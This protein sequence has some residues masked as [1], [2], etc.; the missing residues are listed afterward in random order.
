MRKMEKFTDLLY[1]KP[2]SKYNYF[3][4]SDPKRG[5]LKWVYLSYLARIQTWFGINDMNLV[6]TETT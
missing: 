4:T 3:L 1:N 5:V 2:D 6:Q